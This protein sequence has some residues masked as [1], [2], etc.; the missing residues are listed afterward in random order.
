MSV[1]EC[2]CECDTVFVGR[3]A[4]VKPERPR[5]TSALSMCA[6]PDSHDT[7]LRSH[8][9][10]LEPVDCLKENK[11]TQLTA[12]RFWSKNLHSFFAPRK[13]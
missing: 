12:L 5:F 8:V 10:A 1:D 11:R 13:P 4:I 2:L 9:T 6:S 7:R 3:V